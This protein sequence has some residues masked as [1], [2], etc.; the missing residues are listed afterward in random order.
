MCGSRPPD[1]EQNFNQ[2]SES[3]GML[4]KFPLSTRFRA[5]HF[6]SILVLRPY[7][8]LRRHH[9]SSFR[10]KQ[11][12]SIIIYCQH[13]AR[14]A[15]KSLATLKWIIFYHIAVFFLSHDFRSL[16]IVSLYVIVEKILCLPNFSFQ[17]Q[18]FSKVFFS[19]FHKDVICQSNLL[20]FCLTDTHWITIKANIL[21]NKHYYI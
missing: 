19:D 8:H 7:F 11:I 2:M 5:Y 14:N 16:W 6:F 18:S 4:S 17:I 12:I 9:T 3:T 21:Q 13:A 10:H 15:S 20:F 1:F